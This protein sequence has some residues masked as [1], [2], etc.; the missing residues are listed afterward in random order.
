MPRTARESDSASGVSFVK[1][2]FRFDVFFVKLWLFIA[3]RRSSLPPAVPLTRFLALFD[4]FV[5]AISPLH[6][7]F[8]GRA[9]NHHHVAT[10]EERLRLDLADLLDVLREP[11]QQV[12]AALGMR[13]LAA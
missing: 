9:K 5:F 2:R 6:P 4:V 8:L 12:A 11:Q 3:W 1:A 10:V 13:R 7:R